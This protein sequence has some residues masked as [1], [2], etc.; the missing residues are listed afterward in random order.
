M[1]ATFIYTPTE[2]GYKI[3]TSYE[4]IPKLSNSDQYDYKQQYKFLKA[5]ADKIAD[6]IKTQEE[7]HT[8]LKDKYGN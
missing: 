2:R 7:W 5:I 6:Q 4:D 8:D 1:K 3:E